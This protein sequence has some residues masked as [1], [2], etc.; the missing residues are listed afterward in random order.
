MLT[1]QNLTETLFPIFLAFGYFFHEFWEPQFLIPNSILKK[2]TVAPHELAWDV[3]N[4]WHTSWNYLLGDFKTAFLTPKTL[5][6][7]LSNNLVCNV[8][9]GRIPP[10]TC[11]DGYACSGRSWWAR[12][13]MHLQKLLKNP[14]LLKNVVRNSNASSKT[15]CGQ[16]ISTNFVGS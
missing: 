14:Q 8:P 4:V 3:W 13:P 5:S 1:R 6:S 16:N 2:M 9:F 10:E 15:H 11:T 12:G 7:L